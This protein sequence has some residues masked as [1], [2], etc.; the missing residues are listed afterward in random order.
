MFSQYFSK[1]DQSS[2]STLIH[3]SKKPTK[4]A[5]PKRTFSLIRGKDS[6]NSILLVDKT[7]N[8]H[9]D[10]H[11]IGP[12]DFFGDYHVDFIERGFSEATT[13]VN[14][15]FQSPTWSPRE[16]RTDR[17]PGNEQHP[18]SLQTSSFDVQPSPTWEMED[19]IFSEATHNPSEEWANL[20]FD[21]NY[22]LPSILSSTDDIPL[23]A[24]TPSLASVI[25]ARIKKSGKGFIIRLLHKGKSG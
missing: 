24:T 4:Y 18:Y 21:T 20:Q 19:G 13:A 25:K 11:K 22:F 15:R 12:Q 5:G 23:P 2:G 6:R 1:Q 7:R 17:A 10:A 16:S 14:S 8:K 3:S 9:G